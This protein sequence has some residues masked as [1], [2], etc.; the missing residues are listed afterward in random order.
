MRF[1]LRYLTMTAALVAISVLLI[2]AQTERSLERNASDLGEARLRLVLASLVSTIQANLDFGLPLPSLRQIQELLERTL[3]S[4]PG[5]RAIDVVDD[6]GIALFSS[7]RGAEGE[8]APEAWVAAM[9]ERRDGDLWRAQDRGEL[10]FGLPIVSAIGR[11]VGHVVVVRAAP[12]A[13]RPLTDSLAALL[14]N[15]PL[16]VGAALLAGLA[17]GGLVT[18]RHRPLRRLAQCLAEGRT[19]HAAERDSLARA[20]VGAMASAAAASAAIG[21]TRTELDRIDH[22]R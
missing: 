10:A 19:P 21:A 7:D 22:E 11:T 20:L 3:A 13:W 15:L 14:E 12:Q 16:A 9:N 4:Q 5:L 18:L 2:I 1:A 6:S 17:V 8:P